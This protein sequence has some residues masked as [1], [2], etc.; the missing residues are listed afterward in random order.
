MPRRRSPPWPISSRAA[1]MR[2]TEHPP[3]KERRLQGL[4]ISPG[5][6]IGPA[7]VSDESEISV[8]EQRLAADAVEDELERFRAA[9]ALSAKQL[10]KLK[11]KTAGLPE[12][13]AEEMGYLLDAHLAMLDQSRLIRGVA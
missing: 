11:S 2:T 7:F 1:S 9:V 3:R 12:A 10:R 4:G 13:A 6:A 8:P 5:I